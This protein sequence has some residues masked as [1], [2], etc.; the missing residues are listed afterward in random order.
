MKLDLT[1][2]SKTGVLFSGEVR[3]ITAQ[4]Q[5]G[6]FDIL[7]DHENFISIINE[8]MHVIHMDG[9]KQLIPVRYG[10]LKVSRNHVQVFLD[11]EAR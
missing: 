2:M 3:A 8:D 9:K 6:A 10:L 1:V 5:R 4:N 11:L 7:P